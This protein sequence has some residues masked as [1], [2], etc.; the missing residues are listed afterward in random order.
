MSLNFSDYTNICNK[1]K[2]S[3][4]CKAIHP[5]YYFDADEQNCK[6]FNYGGCVG[7]ENNFK[8]EEECKE[9]CRNIY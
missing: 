9:K 3:G 7:N 1:P 5:R 2:D 6:K 4:P 8:S